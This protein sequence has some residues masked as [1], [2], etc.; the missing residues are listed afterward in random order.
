MPISAH[1]WTIA[2]RL[3]HAVT[4]YPDSPSRPF[5]FEIEDPVAGRLHLSGK[6]RERPGDELLVLVHGLG[7]SADSHYLLRGAPPVE[8]SGLSCLR[9]NLR[10]ADRSGE[11]FYHAG[12]TADLSAALAAPELA[13]FRR[14]YVLG[15]SL[16]GHMVLKAATE[17][18][19]LD[20]R[21]A[22]VAALCSPLDLALA[23][24]AIDSPR[25][26]LYRRYLLRALNQI[27][28]AVAAR[29]PAPLPAAQA[30]RIRTIFEWDERVVAPRHGFAGA[31]DYYARASVAP[32]LSRLTV[33]ALLVNSTRDPMVPAATVRPALAA[34]LPRLTA[35]LLDAGGHVGFPLGF[36]AGLGGGTGIE[37]QILA[38][39]RRQ[40]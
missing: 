28:A 37:A 30:A 21:V 3:R 22:A 25:S 5:G 40:G 20:P 19:G 38:W 23:Q 2:P 14:L 29:G 36:D 6:L 13:R 1:F 24:R 4:P 27:Y 26:A 35:H 34:P 18:E 9:L 39:L 7:G 10:G 11:D 12:L 33:P 17:G 31:D 8:A 15:Y 16:G 32:H